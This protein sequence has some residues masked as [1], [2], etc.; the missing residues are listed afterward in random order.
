MP[1]NTRGD[2]AML[3]FEIGAKVYDDERELFGTVVDA[4]TLAKEQLL[5]ALSNRHDGDGY[6]VI[7]APDGSYHLI[8]SDLDLEGWVTEDVSE[9]D[10]A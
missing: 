4:T 7:I 2:K 3:K 8:D 5:N 6:C 10:A 9:D 1:S